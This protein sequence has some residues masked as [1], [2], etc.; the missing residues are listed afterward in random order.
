[1]TGLCWGVLRGAVNY[2]QSTVSPSRKQ[3]YL[4][5]LDPH[6]QIRTLS[7]NT[8]QPQGKSALG[9]A[10]PN[11]ST[12]I[13]NSFLA[14]QFSVSA[15]YFA[16]GCQGLINN[17]TVKRTQ[18]GEENSAKKS[19]CLDT[20]YNGNKRCNIF[21][22]SSTEVSVNWLLSTSRVLVT[23]DKACQINFMSN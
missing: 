15:T 1:M 17:M 18:R 14:S 9:D 23:V 13:F 7:K 3:S 20:C 4:L 16:L 12:R 11:H 5:S 8:I 10:Y 19:L 6:L 21:F 22:F 2:A